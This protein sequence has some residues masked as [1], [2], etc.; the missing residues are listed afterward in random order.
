MMTETRSQTIVIRIKPVLHD[1]I[2]SE[3]DA[4]NT[5]VSQVVRRILARNYEGK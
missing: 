5:T 2:K 4:D 1:L 3:A